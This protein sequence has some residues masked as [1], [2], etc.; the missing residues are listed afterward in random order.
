MWIKNNYML[1]DDN[2]FENAMHKI[3]MYIRNG[4][5]LND[6]LLL[7]ADDVNGKIDSYSITRMLKA[8]FEIE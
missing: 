2:Y 8:R 3:R 5:V 4:F 1:T 6:T 7:T